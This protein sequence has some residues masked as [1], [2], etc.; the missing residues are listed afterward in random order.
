MEGHAEAMHAV[1]HHGQV[2]LAQQAYKEPTPRPAAPGSGT[3]STAEG[4]GARL[5]KLQDAKPFALAALSAE[6]IIL[7][8]NVVCNTVIICH[9]VVP[10]GKAGT[11]AHRIM[12]V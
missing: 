10:L 11:T 5:R 3:V 2:Q 1:P 6:V 4:T 9:W 8:Y 12:V 7:R